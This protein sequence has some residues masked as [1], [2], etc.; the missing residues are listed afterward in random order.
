MAIHLGPST[1][2]GTVSPQG[3][4]SKCHSLFREIQRLLDSWGTD[5]PWAGQRGLMALE[6][7]A[8]SGVHGD[9]S[10]KVPEKRKTAINQ[11]A[12]FQ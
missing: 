11:R 12:A 7:S 10:A 1:K 2:L 9:P 5:L 6:T 3:H 4:T 8:T